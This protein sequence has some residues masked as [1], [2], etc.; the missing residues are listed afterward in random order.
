VFGVLPCCRQRRLAF[1]AYG[2]ECTCNLI[3][4]KSSAHANQPS[5][6]LS[7]DAVATRRAVP[8]DLLGNGGQDLAKLDIVGFRIV[9][10]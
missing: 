1:G 2:R 10:N 5:S 4:W 6:K 8:I 3:L 9:G 7:L